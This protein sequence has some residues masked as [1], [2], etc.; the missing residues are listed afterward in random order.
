MI[1]IF[2]ALVALLALGKARAE[3]ATVPAPVAPAF[4]Q[5]ARPASP[6]TDPAVKEAIDKAVEKAKE[7]L[8]DEMRAE[9][10][11]AQSA[12]EFMGTVALQP[13]LQ[14]F[15][16]TGYFRLRGDIMHNLNLTPNTDSAGFYYF[17]KP[18][19]GGNNLYETNMRLRLEP[20]INASETVRVKAQIDVL[21]NYVLGSNTSVLTNAPGSPY[22]VPFSSDSRV[23]YPNDPTADRAP[24]VPKRV[25]A[26]LQTPVGLLSFG[27]MPSG[28][29]LGIL[30]SP[31]DRLDSDYGDTVDRIQFALPPIPTPL[32]DL[33]LIP[34]WDFDATGPL[35][36]DPHGEAS[37]GQPLDLDNGAD[38]RTLALKLVRLDTEDEIRRKLDRGEKSVNFGLYWNWRQQVWVYP[39]WLDQGYAGTYTQAPASNTTPWARRD[40]WAQ[41]VSLWARWLSP[42]LRIEAEVVGVSGKAGNANAGSTA[43]LAPAA[44]YMHQYG[45]AIQ[46]EYKA[47]G[48]FSFGLELGTASGDGAPGF[49][50]I[51][52]R[53]TAVDPNVPPNY[54]AIEGPQWG[55]PGD[56]TINNFR[57]N[58]DYTVDLIFYRHIIGQ[59]TDSVYLRP[60]AHIDIFPG[61]HED[62]SVLYAQAVCPSST[63]SSTSQDPAIIHSPLSNPGKKPLALE[64]DSTTT[65]SPTRA[66][67]GWVSLGLLD[68]LA[69]MG[70]GTHVAFLLELGLAARF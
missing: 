32:G 39:E 16:L 53:G 12:A 3:E 5:A 35:M 51:P 49:G 66:F 10:Q 22:P 33:G 65:I 38:A 7:E 13:K 37:V 6:E 27:R 19:R 4:P 21:D 70:G 50:N 59:I 56:N 42:K 1:R 57:F 31:G 11:G 26:E 14:V 69:G 58:P 8:R 64:L 55:R 40:A 48:H 34:I 62:V 67:T 23:Y 17:P 36:Y 43:P 47:T 9:L 45:A 15:E 61:I 20:T 30:T 68:P 29:G 25:W 24:I 60:S 2:V 46:S 44:I 52:N 54:G 18:L 28:W 41:Y 63:P